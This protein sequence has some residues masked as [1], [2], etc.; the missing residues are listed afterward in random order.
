MM[1]HELAAELRELATDPRL[2]TREDELRDLALAI[3]DSD[4]A[5]RWCEVDLFAAFSPEDSIVPSREP[6]ETKRKKTFRWFGIFLSSFL[7]FAPILITWLGLR[8]ATEAYGEVLQANGSE[9]AQQPFLEMWQQ[10]FGGR[11][12][13]FFK[14]DNIALC[15]LVAIALLISWTV[16]ENVTRNSEERQDNTSERDLALLRAR[17]RRALTRAS[18]LLGQVRLS[19]PARFGTELTKTVAEINS[20][21][22]TVSKA[23]TELV[24]A[25]SR[26]WKATQQ[27]TELLTS[28]ASDVRE[29]MATLRTHLANINVAYDDVS[30]AVEQASASIDAVGSSTG[31]AV[32]NVGD[33]L[34]AAITQTTL[35][36]RRAFV[37]EL[38][39]ST[40]SVQSTVGELVTATGSMKDTFN[41]GLTR[42]MK[43]V[44]GT[45][46]DLDS[47]IGEL[48]TATGTMKDTFNDG[49][50]RSMKSVQGTVTDLDSRV[51]E[52][53]TATAGI[54]GAVNRTA[55]SIDSVGATTEKA[56]GLIG[57]QVTDSLVVTAAEFRRT[58]GDTGTEIRE[59]LGDWSTTAHA[60]ASRIEM[61]SDTSGRTI[62]LLEQTHDSLGRLPAAI[63]TVLAE[64]PVRVKEISGGDFAELGLAITRLQ[65]AVDRAAEAVETST[66]A[67]DPVPDSGSG[68]GFSFGFGSSPKGR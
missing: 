54:E 23:Q 7:V 64:L 5:E 15:T 3:T 63:S 25:L 14:F 47:R 43:S 4:R 26:T 18:L 52:L 24:D 53:V 6:A 11:L 30:A 32:A 65:S 67:P 61:V 12:N 39:R 29:T 2:A 20:V 19:S 8:Q 56:V 50:T 55:I 1:D 27:T 35:D 49:L 17:L 59:A 9:A 45:I 60:H 51:G 10:G 66:A 44:Q 33:Q 21:G 68:S 62:A 42:S 57:G 48:I 22:E 16:Y 36:M 38:E 40:K 46:T 31:Q 41:D 28:G 13:G 58:F 37:E 34:A